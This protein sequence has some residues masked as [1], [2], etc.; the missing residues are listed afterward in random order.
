MTGRYSVRVM[1]GEETRILNNKGRGYDT[2]TA[3]HDAARRYER[4]HG[5]VRIETIDAHDPIPTG[6]NAADWDAWRL[7]SGISGSHH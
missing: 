1:R 7:R 2:R 3:A 6:G 5:F 4:K